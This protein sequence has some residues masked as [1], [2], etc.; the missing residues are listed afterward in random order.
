VVE[1]YPAVALAVWGL[2]H[3]GYKGGDVASRAVLAG[4]V[5]AVGEG[6]RGLEVP[7]E[8]ED[9]CRVSDHA[10]DALVAALVAR[11][12]FLGLVGRPGPED[13]V[14]A[15]EEGWIAVPRGGSLGQLV[16]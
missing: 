15:R 4:L 7:A 6:C 13:A 2:P 1:V 9:R 8:V 16:G 12:A 10:F 11:A 14:A 3:R 5:A